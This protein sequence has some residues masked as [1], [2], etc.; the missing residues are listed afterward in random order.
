[1][2]D[3]SNLHRVACWC[4]CWQQLQ[5]LHCNFGELQT[6]WRWVYLTVKQ[7][8]QKYY[9]I[10][11]VLV[12]RNIACS[13]TVEAY[14]MISVFIFKLLFFSW[15]S[16]LATTFVCLVSKQQKKDKQLRNHPNYNTYMFVTHTKGTSWAHKTRKH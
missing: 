13:I 16:T 2:T 6:S 7:V 11:T 4:A 1:M 5:I 15:F 14:T 9:V 10:K 3:T 12:K 8:K